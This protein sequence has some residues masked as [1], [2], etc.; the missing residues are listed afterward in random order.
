MW[1][2]HFLRWLLFLS[3]S[4]CWH[5]IFCCLL[6]FF[7]DDSIKVYIYLA[8]YLFGLLSS[9]VC[10][11]FAKLLLNMFLHSHI[12]NHKANSEKLCAYDGSFYEI[13]CLFCLHFFSQDFSF[14]IL[15]HHPLVLLIFHS[16]FRNN[17]EIAHSCIC[18]SVRCVFLFDLIWLF[19]LLF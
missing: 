3:L 10:S 5:H 9:F 18:L 12:R 16:S 14:S 7:T 6:V 4:S 11:N 13:L 15:H 2:E 1:Y 19:V 17:F 8:A